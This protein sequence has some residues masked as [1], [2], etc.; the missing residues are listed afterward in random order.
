M[1]EH[2]AGSAHQAASVQHLVALGYEDPQD[3]AERWADLERLQLAQL[4]S[5]EQQ[6][7]TGE[8]TAAIASLES[9]IDAAP[10]W[11]AP[12]QLLARAYYRTGQWRAASERLEW[13]ESHGV[14]HAELALLRARLALRGRLLEAARDHAAYA[15]ALHQPLEAAD[16]LIGEVEFRLGNLSAAEAAYR[17]AAD[18]QGPAAAAWAG[19]AAVALRRGELEEAIDWSL[20]AIDGEPS[21]A[22][23]HY[24]LGLALWRFHRP[25]EATAALKAAASLSPQMAGPYRWLTAIAARQGDKVEAEQYRQLG[26][27]VVVRRRQIRDSD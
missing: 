17:R 18:V 6:L 23:S 15:K 4:A 21:L 16:V 1:Q 8:L 14:E 10:D 2:E 25:Q 24:R 9:M 26:R 13:L 27:A 11:A 20:Q 7:K 19:L 22:A 12:H 5:A 3:A